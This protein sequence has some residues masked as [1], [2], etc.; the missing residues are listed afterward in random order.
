MYIWYDL[1]DLPIVLTR[2]DKVAHNV[3]S[4]W[5]IADKLKDEGILHCTL[6]K[7]TVTLL[8]I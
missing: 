5:K 6:K 8:L 7:V 3:K 4:F 2:N 1:L